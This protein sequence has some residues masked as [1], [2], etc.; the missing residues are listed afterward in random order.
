PKSA[1][2]VAE[3]ISAAANTRWQARYKALEAARELPLD[4]RRRVAKAFID[5]ENSWVRG[6]ASF[7][8]GEE[9]RMP[10]TSRR[11][12]VHDFDQVI[13]GAR[14]NLDQRTSLIKLLESAE[15]SGSF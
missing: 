11:A 15:E 6:L 12:I 14:L 3:L 1:D 5:D 9:R 10:R 13:R 8:A 7:L 4:M 2:N